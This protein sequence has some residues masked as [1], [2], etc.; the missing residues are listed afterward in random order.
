M[1]DDK[2]LALREEQSVAEHSGDEVLSAVLSA[3]AD[4]QQSPERLEKFLAVAERFEAIK[5]KRAYV[6]AFHAAK[7]EMDGIKITKEGKI[8]Y[9]DGSIIKY[10]KYD[11]I[12]RHIKPVLRRYGLSESYSYEYTETPPKV[13]CVMTLMHTAGHSETFRSV[14]LPM[15][16]SSGGKTDIQGAGS[17]AS[18][19]KRF[20]IVPAFDIVCEDE[21]DDG[22]G[23]GVGDPIDQ[24]E[25]DEIERCLQIMEE[26]EPGGRRRF[27]AW[28]AKNQKVSEIAEIRQGA[29]LSVVMRALNAKLASLDAKLGRLK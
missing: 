16:D 3:V 20:V 7:D 9:R 21:D 2:Q 22:S 11:D 26:K 27:M 14:P 28:L 10:A 4:P 25:R 15:V 5:A 1:S 6:Q 18:Y 23:Q 29:G 17:V 12:A 19:G 24:E 8:Q 13:T